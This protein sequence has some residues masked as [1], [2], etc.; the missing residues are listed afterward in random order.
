MSRQARR[1][2]IALGRKLPEQ[3]QNIENQAKK[4]LNPAEI[5]IFKCWIDLSHSRPMSMGPGYVS[6]RDIRHYCQTKGYNEDMTY[7]L[8]KIVPELCEE[9]IKIYND[10]MDAEHKAQEAKMQQAR[11]ARPIG[12]GRR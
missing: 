11:A 6:W 8:H 10:R 7:A 4:K 5:V 2:A 12:R 9:D 1:N 3:V